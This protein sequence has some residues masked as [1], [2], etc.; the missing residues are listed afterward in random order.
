MRKTIFFLLLLLPVTAF[1]ATRTWTG[2]TS[3]AWSLAANWGGTAPVSGDDLVFPSGAANQST[4]AND[5]P[6]GTSF[7]SI[8]FTGGSYFLTGNDIV[9]G[10]GGI[11]QNAGAR[12]V[13]HMNIQLTGPETWTTNGNGDFLNFGFFFF[14]DVQTYALTVN[15]TGTNAFQLSSAVIKGSAVSGSLV[16]NGTGSMLVN[17]T[18]AVNVPV[19]V[20]SPAIAS[21]SNGGALGA[22]LNSGSTLDVQPGSFF[23]LGA[24]TL[25]AG[26]Q[27]NFVLNGTASGS[28][29]QLWFSNFP[30]L[31]GTLNVSRGFTPAPG[32]VITIGNNVSANPISG[33]FAGLPEGSTINVQGQDFVISYQGGDG[34]DLTL[35]AGAVTG[36]ATTT[37]LASTPNPAT[38]GQTVTFTATVSPATNTGTVTLYGG[39]VAMASG[40]PNA[41]GVV[42]F[43][44]PILPVGSINTH[45]SYSGAP[46]FQPSNSS[47]LVQTVTAVTPTITLQSSNNPAA[48][49]QPVTFTINFS[50]TAVAPATVFFVDNGFG[51]ATIPIDSSG[52]GQYTTN[53]LTAGTH[54]ISI[55]F[56]ASGAGN[57]ANSNTV[58]QAVSASQSIPTLDPRVLAALGTILAAA[59][60]MF[61][62]RS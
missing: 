49:G 7:H 32:T 26:S 1:G 10:A 57:A 28:F 15:M 38:F 53:S 25:N 47:T 31:G 12:A 2:A 19:I 22:T 39:S 27:T 45:A 30:K 8:T 50:P 3:G 54:N 37:T 24:L 48:L 16:L 33:T 58:V 41:S 62:R 36:A 43:S 61:V 34:N 40:T 52:H 56:S 29:S 51:T 18:G 13:V 20:N 55:H 21:V 5:L 14:I 35:T 42:T 4:C 9:L 59:G 11:T 46:G 44:I 23:S 60:A 6:A 17:N